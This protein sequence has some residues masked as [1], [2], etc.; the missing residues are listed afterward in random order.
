MKQFPIALLALAAALATAAAAKADSFN[1]TFTDT[2]VSGSGTLTGTYE[3]AGNPWLITGGTGTFTDP[4]DSGSVSLVADLNGTTSSAQVDGVTYDDLLD[5]LQISGAYLDEDGL[6]F[7]FGN[8]DYINIFFDYSAGG[9]GPVYYGWD[10]SPEGNGDDGFESATGLF[11]ASEAPEP[12]TLLLMAT[13]ILAL[14]LLLFWKAKA[15][16]LGLVLNR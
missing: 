8:G 2:G 5:P 11:D 9:S 14:A 16:R 1:F 15:Q 13:E 7:Q 10:D 3:G 6:L 12:G 4:D